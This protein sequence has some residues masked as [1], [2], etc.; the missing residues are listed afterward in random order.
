MVVEVG[1][2]PAAEQPVAAQWFEG[3]PVS[4]KLPVCSS[5]STVQWLDLGS[6]GFALTLASAVVAA[7]SQFPSVAST[8]EL[9]AQC[10]LE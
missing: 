3:K 2:Q 9:E 4:C 7:S 8:T 10:H 1:R 5:C 6:T